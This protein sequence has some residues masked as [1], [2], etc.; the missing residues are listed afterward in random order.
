MTF[1]ENFDK[2]KR[3]LN[4]CRSLNDKNSIPESI[5]EAY[6]S[7]IHICPGCDEIA[8]GEEL[9]EE[10][11]CERIRSLNVSTEIPQPPSGARPSDG[12][13]LRLNPTPSGCL[14]P[15]TAIASAFLFMLYASA[16]LLWEWSTY[17]ATWVK[18]VTQ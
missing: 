5:D 7:G 16:H 17:I 2:D 8:S 10:C 3:K 11:A 13:P 6:S 15:A 18:D 9:C 4:R 14:L 12:S 1:S